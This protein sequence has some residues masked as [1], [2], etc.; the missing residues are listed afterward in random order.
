[1]DQLSAASTFQEKSDLHFTLTIISMCLSASIDS[2]E[3]RVLLFG[4]K[5]CCH[6]LLVQV[7]CSKIIDYLSCQ[8]TPTA[9]LWM[10]LFMP[11]LCRSFSEMGPQRSEQTLQAQHLGE[12]FNSFCLHHSCG[13]RLHHSVWSS[14]AHAGLLKPLPHHLS[15]F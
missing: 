5:R 13:Q 10:L 9:P 6:K 11:F 4:C 1:M 12:R 8:E 15:A 14:A 7:Q 2:L 3:G